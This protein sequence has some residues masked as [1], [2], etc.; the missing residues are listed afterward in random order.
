LPV[1]PEGFSLSPARS[2]FLEFGKAGRKQLENFFQLGLFIREPAAQFEQL[3]VAPA[4]RFGEFGQLRPYTDQP[5]PG[6]IDLFAHGGCFAQAADSVL[7][8][9]PLLGYLRGAGNDLGQSGIGGLAG[10]GGSSPKSGD[11]ASR[12]SSRTERIERNRSF[13]IITALFNQIESFTFQSTAFCRFHYPPCPGPPS[14]ALCH[15]RKTLIGHGRR[16]MTAINGR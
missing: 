13:R 15:S 9:Q 10:A 1:F 8:Q 11:A 7:G 2:K 16:L 5:L 14:W 3:I 6:G 12:S 4:G